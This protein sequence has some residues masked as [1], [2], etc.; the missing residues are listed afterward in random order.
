M[1]TVYITTMMFAAFLMLILPLSAKNTITK[2]PVS[3][4]PQTSPE[5]DGADEETVKIKI[6]KTDEI[7]SLT[8]EDYIFGVV[9]AEMPALYEEEALKAQAVAAYTYFLSQKDSNKDEEFDIT[10]DYTLHQAFITVDSARQKWGEG[11]DLYENKIRGCVKSVLY[12]KVLYDNKPASTVYHAI[13]FGVTESAADVWGGDYSYL[14]SVDSSFDKLAVDY[15]SEAVF[16][17][18]E[19]K[20]L[21]SSLAEIADADENCITDIKRTEAGSVKS[22]SVCGKNISGSDFRKALSLRSANFD[23]TYSSGKYTFTVRGYG[24]SIG[25]SQNGA[26]YMAQQ[27][28]TYDEILLH[29]YTGCTIE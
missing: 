11:A 5:Q 28:K 2:L 27:G 20:N 19:M 1:K 23:L 9:A 10:D 3:A 14:V 15:L 4:L 17:S 18:E 8:L 12:K 26:N 6:T 13:S 22:L 29:Y 7:L 24:H 16:T 21:L 25:M